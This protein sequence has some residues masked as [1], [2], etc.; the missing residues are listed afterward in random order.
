MTIE[1]CR[2]FTIGAGEKAFTDESTP[3]KGPRDRTFH[4]KH[5]KLDISF[6]E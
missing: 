1:N 5:L 6:D 3:E 4:V 2:S